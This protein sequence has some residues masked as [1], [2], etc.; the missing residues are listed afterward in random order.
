MCGIFGSTKLNKF[1]RLYC[2]N[3]QRGDFAYGFIYFKTN[4]EMHTRRGDGTCMLSNEYTWKHKSVYDKFLGHTQAPTSSERDYHPDTSHP[5]ECGNFIVAH[6]GVL[7]NHLTL[8]ADH[9]IPVDNIKVDSQI[10]PML[11]DDLY[12]GSDVMAIK[13]VCSLLR[14]IFSCWIFCK[15]TK[16]IY[17]VRSG[18]T[19]YTDKDMT[20]FSS[21]EFGD[22]KNEL[23]AGVIYCY[24]SEGL[25]SVDTFSTDNPF[26]I[27]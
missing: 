2:K 3:K 4:G 1:E 19:L 21:L 17:V 27:L 16:L 23:D 22:V 13:E 11:L 24:T 14:G 10:I 20:S 5:F 26:L 7:E 18:C 12:V 6:N 9:R 15:T 25:T 8:A